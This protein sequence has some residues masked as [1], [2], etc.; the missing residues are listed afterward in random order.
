[1][2]KKR[3]KAGRERYRSH[4]SSEGSDQRVLT[5]RQMSAH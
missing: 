4:A 1:M 5:G 2:K 3:E